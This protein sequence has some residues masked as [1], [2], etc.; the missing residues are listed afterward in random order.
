MIPGNGGGS[1][2]G[3][4]AW[5]AGR[6]VAIANVMHFPFVVALIPRDDF[7]TVRESGLYPDTEFSPARGHALRHAPQA[8]AVVL[9]NALREPPWSTLAAVDMAAGKILWQVPLGGT[10]DL[11]GMP[12]GFE[13]GMPGLGGPLVTAGGLVFIGAVMDD[14]LRA[15]DIG[16]GVSCG[17]A[18]C[19]PAGRPRR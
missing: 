1:N 19:P 3:G 18:A 10:R 15:Y 5:D 12:F 17:A 7:D 11:T 16:T 8:A 4:I 9:G 6:Q 14:Y 13:W 2:W